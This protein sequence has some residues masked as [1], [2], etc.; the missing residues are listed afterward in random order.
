MS[1][2][3]S[4]KRAL[5]VAMFSI[6]VCYFSS[7][8]LAYQI[9]SEQLKEA[10]LFIQQELQKIEKNIG[11]LP[12]QTQ[13]KKQELISRQKCIEGIKD[14]KPEIQS[15]AICKVVK[16]EI[17]EGKLKRSIIDKGLSMLPAILIGL[18]VLVIALSMIKL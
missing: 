9:T 14:Q 12:Q 1:F 4:T 15:M 16:Q 13:V 3:S 11:T 17:S 18:V 7:S 5:C 2:S 6:L 10:D 8:A